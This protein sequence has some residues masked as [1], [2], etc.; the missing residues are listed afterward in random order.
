MLMSTP[1]KRMLPGTRTTTLHLR[2]IPRCTIKSIVPKERVATSKSISPNNG[3]E[4][5]ARNKMATHHLP[6]VIIVV[7]LLVTLPL[8]EMTLETTLP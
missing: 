4:E 5:K 6:V 3:K 8:V 2:N 1:Q 7:P